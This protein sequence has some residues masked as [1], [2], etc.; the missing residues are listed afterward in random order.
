[1]VA[2]APEAP[3]LR[4]WRRYR[5]LF[6]KILSGSSLWTH[7]LFRGKQDRRC[8][9]R[10]R[11]PLLRSGQVEADC[12]MRDITEPSASSS[13]DQLSASRPWSDDRGSPRKKTPLPP[14][15]RHRKCAILSRTARPPPRLHRRRAA[16]P[17]VQDFGVVARRPS[18][19]DP[20]A[21]STSSRAAC[22]STSAPGAHSLTA[23]SC[24]NRLPA[25]RRCQP[26][27]EGS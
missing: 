19:Q 13:N 23:I 3:G 25:P 11:H 5:A 14:F 17:D 24:P 15:W 6:Q 12:F 20:L 1:M 8:G 26:A 7:G 16:P 4:D 18:P 9:F 21:L 22:T 10:P 2:A 27:T